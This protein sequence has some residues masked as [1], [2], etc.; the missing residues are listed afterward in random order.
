MKPRA[1]LTAEWRNLA[2]LNFPADPEILRPLVPQ[3]TELDF[4]EGRTFLS[5]VGFQFVRTRIFGVAIPFHTDFEEVNLRFYVRRRT[6][7]GWRRG[8]V[9]VRELVPRAAIALIARTFY[10]EPYLA[11]PM[12]HHVRQS[13]SGIH[14]IYGWLRAGRWEFLQATGLGSPK[15]IEP[16]S[17]EEFITEHYWGYT[18]LNGRCA[19]YQVEHPSWEVWRA[20]RATVVADIAN[21]YGQQFVEPLSVPPISAFIAVGSPVVVRYKNVL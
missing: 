2:M 7:E 3:G 1:F 5:I 19:E 18:A 21:L 4:F 20:E 11:L 16:G 10:H 6:D 14:V 12:R 17:E 15:P 9:F 13:E 8:V